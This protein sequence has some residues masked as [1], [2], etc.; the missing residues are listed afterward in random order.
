MFA[1]ARTLAAAL[2]A[3]AALA[4]CNVTVPA[5]A[6]I[7]PKAG[8]VAQNAARGQVRVALAGLGKAYQ[9]LATRE[10]VHRLELELTSHPGGKV[11][12]R[13][14]GPK[15][16]AK[17]LVYVDFDGVATGKAT[18]AVRAYDA[19]GRAIGKGENG[20]AVAAGKTSTV[21]VKVKLDPAAGEGRVAAVVTFEEG[22]SPEE[23]P[24]DGVAAFR[25]A[26]ADRD[27]WLSVE[28]YVKGW[29]HAWGGAIAYPMPAVTEPAVAP[30]P[31][32]ASAIARADQALIAPCW[33]GEGVSTDVRPFPFPCEDPARRD[34]RFRDA[35]G[36]GR[37]SLAEFLGD[38]PV[39]MY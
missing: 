22:V 27:G 31:G 17:P 25:K 11:Q 19:Q 29:P 10:D 9:V 33:A 2:V 8:V 30:E 18:L 7:T 37:L 36:D 28:E 39:V 38:V 15:E 21:H 13:K 16:L 6:V 3:C 1:T 32:V 26:D 24:R 12:A 23:P 14:V 5:A 4:G 34:F 20:T 35:D